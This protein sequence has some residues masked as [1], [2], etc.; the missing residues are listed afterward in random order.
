VQVAK[1]ETAGSIVGFGLF[2]IQVDFEEHLLVCERGEFVAEGE[3]VHAGLKA[4]FNVARGL[5]ALRDPESLG[6][7]PIDPIGVILLVGDDAS[8]D[9]FVKV[10]T[11]N[12]RKWRPKAREKLRTKSS[13]TA[14][15]NSA[16]VRRRARYAAN[17]MPAVP[18]YFIEHMLLLQDFGP[19]TAQSSG[20]SSQK[21]DGRLACNM[22]GP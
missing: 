6:L 17:R 22:Y 7:M 18:M 4:G 12:A 5:L 9:Q 2:V 15:S 8:L 10:V 19:S 13:P 16:S 20:V 21:I 14:A 3:I 1:P 11:A